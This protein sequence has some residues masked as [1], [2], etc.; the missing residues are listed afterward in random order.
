MTWPFPE[1]EITGE[2]A[3]LRG[4]GVGKHGAFHS[5]HVQCYCL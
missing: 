3:G 5:G 1:T 2:G 4:G